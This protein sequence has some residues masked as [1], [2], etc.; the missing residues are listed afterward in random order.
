M[1]IRNWKQHFTCFQFPSQIEFW[2]QFLFFAYFELPNK[3]FS[4]KNRKLFLKTENKRKKQLPN[5]SL[6]FYLHQNLLYLFYL[7][8]YCS[9][10]SILE[11]NLMGNWIIVNYVTFGNFFSSYFLFLKIIFFSEIKKLVWQSKMYRK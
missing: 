2:K 10:G 8:T 3:F 7:H 5:I 9:S 11:K 6:A 1:K 4:I